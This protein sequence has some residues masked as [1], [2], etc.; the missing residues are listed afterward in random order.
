MSPEQIALVQNSFSK[1]PAEAGALLFYEKLF[2]LDPSLRPLFPVDMTEQR[3]KLMAMIATAVGG[4]SQLD[5]LLPAVRDLGARHA[6]YG[7]QPSHYDTVGQALIETLG[8]ALGDDFT[9][10]LEQA[11]VAVYTALS[12]TMIEAASKQAA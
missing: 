2:T 4:L 11:W 12:S 6:G 1:I 3:R 8:E 10:E 7:V 5:R 9:P